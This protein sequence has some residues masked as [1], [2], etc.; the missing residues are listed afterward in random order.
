[1]RRQ[2][3]SYFLSDKKTFQKDFFILT[4]GMKRINYELKQRTITI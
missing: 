2:K 4:E 3:A 1:M